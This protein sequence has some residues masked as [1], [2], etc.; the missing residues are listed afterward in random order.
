M[1]VG[2]LPAMA[3]L[4]AACGAGNAP[5]T[6]T[7]RDAALLG[8]PGLQWY[9]PQEFPTPPVRHSVVFP[10]VKGTSGFNLHSY[11][12]HFDGR[13][14]AMWS[15][16]KVREEDPDQH[17]R[18]ATSE[19]GHTWSE[20]AVLAPD[21]DGDDGPLRWIARGM[22][23]EDGKLRALGA[24]IASADYGKQ[25][26]DVVWKDLDLYH[27]EWD[28]TAWQE[29]GLFASACMN[30]YA[31]SR[32]G[33]Y[34]A[35]A[36]RDGKMNL[37]MALRDGDRGWKRVPLTAA[38]PFDRMD[39][40]TWYQDDDGVIHMLIRDN[41]RSKRILRSLSRDGG[42]SW[43]TPVYTNY[44]DARSKNYSGRLSDGRFFLINNP[45]QDAR[46]PLAVSVSKDGWVFG[47]PA[48]IR[49]LPAEAS[50]SRAGRSKDFQYPHA[51]E[52]GDSLW[53]IYST[54][55]ADIEITEVPLSALGS[56]K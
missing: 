29:N 14:W 49:G 50:L 48:V 51:L 27:F 2:V 6:E 1:V 28:G 21:P 35:M 56:A 8:D 10:G 43:T 13:F 26:H 52:H 40:P 44:P 38:V 33:D 9:L 15:S 20:S 31:P 12:A 5:N 53:V 42:N 17:L 7:V 11:L 34:V 22:W 41:N 46:Y 25:G 47:N 24:R 18:F 37:F 3:L 30:N 16:A 32:L 39:E 54:D 19:D 4:L 55:K 36:C 23:V 45:N